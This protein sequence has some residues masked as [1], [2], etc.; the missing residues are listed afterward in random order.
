MKLKFIGYLLLIM[1]LSTPHFD[2]SAQEAYSEK[3]V[4]W[5]EGVLEET[6]PMEASLDP[7]LWL[8]SGGYFTVKNRVGATVQGMLPENDRWRLAH[9]ISNP[10]D[11][12]DG[13]RPQNIFRLVTRPRFADLTQELLFYI[14]AYN[15]VDSEERK[16]SNGV[17]LMSRYK[18]GDHLYYAGIRVDGRPIIKKKVG[19][20]YY[21]LAYP[22]AVYPGIYDRLNNTNLIPLKKWT[23]LRSSVATL[24]NGYVLLRLW[25]DREA[26][27]EW[28]LVAEALDDGSIAIA[29]YDEGHAGI[30]ADFMDAKFR[31]YRV[32]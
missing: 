6:S 18:D 16:E 31:S 29:P 13:F 17:L 26:L 4:G 27:G 30:R 9:S 7:K 24:E 23:G 32:W 12:E 2:T 3:K 15:V 21:N 11:T 25:L 10:R 28:E 5:R 14:A 22:D 8:N 1:A 19:K 20:T